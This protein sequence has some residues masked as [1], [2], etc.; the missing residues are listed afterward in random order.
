MTCKYEI[1]L[2]V[3]RIF[4]AG[5][6]KLLGTRGHTYISNLVLCNRTLFFP[7]AQSLGVRKTKA[8][9]VDQGP[10][11]PFYPKKRYKRSKSHHGWIV[12]HKPII[13]QRSR[14]DGNIMRQIYGINQRKYRR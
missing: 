9:A 6:S 1:E 2:N 8:S 13:S 12:L 5:N 11:L 4:H 14:I 3:S 7:V 10:M